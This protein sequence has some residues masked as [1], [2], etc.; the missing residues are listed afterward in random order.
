[1]KIAAKILV[2]V[3]TALTL[4][5]CFKDEKQGTLMR[6]AVYSQNVESDPIMKATDL[7]AYAFWV[8]KA[9]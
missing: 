3:V 9:P 8:E 2:F 5:G 1:M 4:T 7:E 6:I